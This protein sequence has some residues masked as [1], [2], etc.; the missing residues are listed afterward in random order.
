MAKLS[1]NCSSTSAQIQGPR[2]VYWYA[3][4]MNRSGIKSVVQMEVNNCRDGPVPHGWNECMRSCK[5]MVDTRKAQHV[6][7]PGSRARYINSGKSQ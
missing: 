4:C 2:I 7:L 6:P 3:Y 5:E 1:N